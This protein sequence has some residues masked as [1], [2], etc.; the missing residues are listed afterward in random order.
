MRHGRRAIV[1]SAGEANVNII[2]PAAAAAGA[3]VAAVACVRAD[4]SLKTGARLPVAVRMSR[5][6]AAIAICSEETKES[7]SESVGFNEKRQ[8]SPLLFFSYTKKQE[9]EKDHRKRGKRRETLDICLRLK[10]NGGL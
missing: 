4:I 8:I 1:T 3:G 5:R 9:R 6:A 7:K 10:F 2:S